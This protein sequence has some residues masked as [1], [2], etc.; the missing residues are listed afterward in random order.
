MKVQCNFN[1]AFDSSVFLSNNTNKLVCL[2]IFPV[3]LSV[4]LLLGLIPSSHAQLPIDPSVMHGQA[5][6]DTVGNH[7]TVINSPDTILDW[8]SFSIDANHGVHFQQQD[9]A[10]QVLNRVTGNDPS[11]IFGSLTSNGNVWLINPHGVLFGEGARVDVGGLVASTLDISNLDFLANHYNFNTVGDITSGVINRGEIRTT[12]GGRVWLA[13]GQVVNE[14]LVQAPDGN[15]VLAAGKSIEIVDSGAPDVIVR[16]SAPENEAVN[17]GVLVANNGNVDVHGSIV[18]QS[19]IVRANS[20][21]T[22]AAGRV[23]LKASQTLALSENSQTQADDGAIKLEANTLN[24]N[25]EVSANDITLTAEEILQQGNIHA[26]G[27]DVT[28]TAE[29][30]IYLDGQV[31]VSNLHGSGGNIQLNTGK[32]EGMTGGSLR[33]DGEQGGNIRIEG[34]DTATFSSTL[35]AIGNTQG[36]DIEVTG[37]KVYLLNADINASGGSKGGAVHLGGGWQGSGDLPHAREVLIGVGSE[38]KAD[39]NNSGGEIAVWSTERSEHY[40]LLQARDGGRIEFSSRGEI[41]LAGDLQAGVGGNVLLDPKNLIITDN[42]PD[43]LALVRKVFAGSVNGQPLLESGDNFGLSVDLDGDRM[44]VGAPSNSNGGAVHLFTGVDTENNAGL[45]WQRKL[46]SGIDGMRALQNSDS[47]GTAV[48]LDGDRL[49]VGARGALLGDGNSGA[50]HMFNGVGE[51]FSGLTWRNELASGTGADQMS[52]LNDFDFFG[53]ALA[54]DGDH[55]AVGA[56]GDSIA[57]GNRGAV[58]L[59]DGVGTNNFTGLAL[60]TKLASGDGAIGMPPLADS[61][62][63]G[64]S[65]ALNADLLAVG[66]LNDSAATNNRGAVHL[67]SGVETN[68]FVGLIWQNKLTSANGATGMPVLADSDFFGWSLAMNGG[69]LAV[70][71]FGDDT[72]GNNRGAVYLFT[73]ATGD[74]SKIALQ[75]KIASNLGANNMQALADGDGF[76]WSVAF[77]GDRLAVGASENNE[78]SSVYLFNGLSKLDDVIRGTTFAADPSVTSYITPATLTA[79]LDSGNSVELQANNDIEVQSAINVNNTSENGVLSLQAGRNIT[80]DAKIT[81]GNADFTAVAGDV[82]AIANLNDGTSL[83]DEGTPTLTITNNASLD[84]GTGTVVLAA[85]DGDFIN[86]NGDSAVLTSGEGRRLIY[87]N[88]PAT[89]IEGFSEASNDRAFNQPFV[90]GSTPELASSGNWF[91][92]NSTAEIDPSMEQETV[93][94]LVQ[95][96]N[97]AVSG[98]RPIVAEP[99]R[100]G[101]IDTTASSAFNQDFLNL[102][103]AQ[104]SFGLLDLKRMSQDDK[105]QLLIYRKEFKEKLFAEAIYKLELDPSLADVLICKDLKELDQGICRISETQR[106]E[107][108]SKK[109]HEQQRGRSATNIINIPQIER[110]YVV[111]FGIDQYTDTT[112]PPLENAVFDA[113]TLG[114]VFANYMGY[115]VRVVKNATRADM[116]R[117]L[118]QLSVDMG[119]SDSVV[120]Y[121]AGHGYTLKQ[122]GNGYWIP[123]DATATDP[124]G[125][126]SNDSISQMLKGINSKQIM[127]VSDSCYSGIFAS[128]SQSGFGDATGNPGDIL[129]KRSVPAMASGGDEPVADEGR[130]GHS[131]FAWYLIQ[132]IKNVGSWKAGI[133]LFRE[134]QTKVSQSFPQTPQ[135]GGVISAGHEDGGDYLYEF[136]RLKD[137]Q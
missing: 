50:V 136:R 45:T 30:S 130:E 53:T 90:P 37:E 22:D 72:A 21:N 23:V 127:L 56:S 46:A 55:L 48:A 122:T 80:I 112:I 12:L 83:K 114:D 8:Q 35:S 1:R 11:Q 13:G 24:N 40:G 10:S 63:F 36:G 14:G 86:R 137:L 65:L 66:A 75:E 39:G 57:G 92:Y 116:V 34:R 110:K 68:D 49:V 111:L 62:F 29:S 78:G 85:V 117:T 118:N 132:E 123:G 47:F 38:I 107:Y 5:V 67:F 52:V 54:L 131:I 124:E 101:V 9:A 82:D 84:I 27:G 81:T 60:Q 103:L 69:L 106:D 59:F 33:A 44:V 134:V 64:W 129:N 91:L 15:I 16:V 88:S 61:D 121:Y 89:S 135:Y 70:G 18:N 95:N 99:T 115:E 71:A 87:A 32:L 6:I 125:W 26:L 133:N 20:V 31:D 109:A 19:G 77:D 96:L 17:L 102:A 97:T 105:Q 2:S 104:Q 108:K 100:S 3:L 79:L 58:Y 98:A 7:M 28:M 94:T 93:N 42:P 120:V 119:P 25:G 51:D 76:G 113:Q 74:F 41:R 73:D 128:E 43:S 126:I 4:F